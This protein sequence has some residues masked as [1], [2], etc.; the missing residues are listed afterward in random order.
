MSWNLSE[1]IAYYQKQGAPS[2]QTALTQLLLEVQLECGGS[3]PKALLPEIAQG[4]AIKETFLLALIRRM[5]RLRLDDGHL[6][7]LCAGPNCSKAAALAAK[8]EQ[9]AT[10]NIRLKF[11]PCMRL[12]GKGPNF[13]LDGTLYHKATPEMLEQLLTTI[14]RRFP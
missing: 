8:A 4:L 11:V 13:K 3:V 6:L 2:D 14:P 5:P 7:E 10:G 12:C 9:L 1:A